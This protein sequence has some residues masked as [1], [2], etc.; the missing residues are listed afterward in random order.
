[1]LG[2]LRLAG[3]EQHVGAVS[4]LVMYRWPVGEAS[5]VVLWLSQWISSGEIA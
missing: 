5:D 2:V 3:E 1:M 4:S